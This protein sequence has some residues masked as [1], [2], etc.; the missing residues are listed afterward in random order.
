M[1]IGGIFEL[2][3]IFG[4]IFFGPISDVIGRKPIIFAFVL[5]AG[6]ANMVSKARWPRGF[7][8]LR[9]WSA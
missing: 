3:Q 1:L 5:I 2:G 7:K 4:S 6:L 8:A 9:L